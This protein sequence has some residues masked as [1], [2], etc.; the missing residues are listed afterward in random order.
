MLRGGM[1]LSTNQKNKRKEIFRKIYPFVAII[2]VCIIAFTAG[3]GE[4]YNEA[5]VYANEFIENFTHTPGSCTNLIMPVKDYDFN[6]SAFE[7]KDSNE[8]G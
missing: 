3:Y 7:V 5:V 8:K 6:L 2:M 1:N 4:A